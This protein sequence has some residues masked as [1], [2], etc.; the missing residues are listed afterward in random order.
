MALQSDHPAGAVSP[1]QRT[2]E[3]DG[4]V[5]VA[6]AEKFEYKTMKEWISAMDSRV[7][8]RKLEAWAERWS[9][10]SN[11]VCADMTNEYDAIMGEKGK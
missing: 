2:I 8:G 1:G 9:H 6:A 7:R 4:A 11:H 5:A 10:G 3:P